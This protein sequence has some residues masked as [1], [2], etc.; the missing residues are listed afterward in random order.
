[1][2]HGFMPT[3]DMRWRQLLE[4]RPKFI[5]DVYGKPDAL[6]V[7]QLSGLVVQDPVAYLTTTRLDD[8]FKR[9]V[10]E[11]YS[12]NLTTC[13]GIH[14]ILNITWKYITHVSGGDCKKVYHTST[15]P[16][17]SR[18]FIHTSTESMASRGFIG[19]LWTNH[20]L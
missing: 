4:A 15:E 12:C 9:I 16:M 13:N 11:L 5:V 7:L 3:D 10:M 20:R 17:V 1:M 6:D 14:G 8:F 19:P 18:G 2:Q